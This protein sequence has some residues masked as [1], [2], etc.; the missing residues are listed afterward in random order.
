M[1]PLRYSLVSN[2]NKWLI[3]YWIRKKSTRLNSLG[4]PISIYKKRRHRISKT[5][6]DSIFSI[7]TQQSFSE[8]D[9]DSLNILIAPNAT[10]FISLSHCPTENIDFYQNKQMIKQH[11][12]CMLLYQ[13]SAPNSHKDRFAKCRDAFLELLKEEKVLLN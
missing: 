13:K 4:E 6:G 1:S 7:F 3:I 5:K 8:L 11:A 12:Y 9:T 10:S 2:K